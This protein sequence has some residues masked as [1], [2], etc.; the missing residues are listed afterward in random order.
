MLICNAAPIRHRSVPRKCNVSAVLGKNF[1][2]LFPPLNSSNGRRLCNCPEWLKHFPSCAVMLCCVFFPRRRRRKWNPPDRF[3]GLRDGIAKTHVTTQRPSSFFPD[4]RSVC[5]STAT[6]KQGKTDKF[7][8]IRF[9]QNWTSVKISHVTDTSGRIHTP[10]RSRL[11]DGLN[12][13][14]Q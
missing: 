13:Q 10:S 14:G 5:G 6:R 4:F 11:M 1:L 7:D 2:F 8:Q 12:P 9:T 3:C